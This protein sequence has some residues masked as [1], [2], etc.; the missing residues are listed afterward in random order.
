MSDTS[1]ALGCMRL[2]QLSLSEAEQ[3]TLDGI[4]H[5][6]HFFD[7]ADIY[8][9]G[10]SETRFGQVLQLHP[11]LRDKIQIQSKCSVL[12]ARVP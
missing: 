6:I 2:F 5:G 11:G 10:E 7:H 9:R 12:Q 3:R 4:Q 1:L 8:G